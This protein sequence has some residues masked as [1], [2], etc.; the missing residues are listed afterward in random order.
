[1]ETKTERRLVLQW[2]VWLISKVSKDVGFQS[3]SQYDT[4]NCRLFNKF[5]YTDETNISFIL[6]VNKQ[7]HNILTFTYPLLTL[8]TEVLYFT[9]TFPVSFQLSKNF[10]AEK[11]ENFLYNGYIITMGLTINCL[12][13]F[14]LHVKFLQYSTNLLITPHADQRHSTK[15]H[16]KHTNNKT[17]SKQ[18][19]CSVLV[20]FIK[21]DATNFHQKKKEKWK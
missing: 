18:T 5:W 8:Y 1:M 11:G 16:K 4:L 9:S 13:V 19:L 21:R 12:L 6:L 17:R 3:I 2:D 20:K 14:R 15:Q 7:P 10:F